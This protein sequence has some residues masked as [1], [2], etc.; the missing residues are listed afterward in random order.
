MT[1]IAHQVQ[2]KVLSCIKRKFPN[3]QQVEYFS[4]G[5]TGQYTNFKNV[6]KLCHH[7][8][9]FGLEATLPF[10]AASHGKSTCDDIGVTVKSANIKQ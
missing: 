7:K 8:C 2:K 1:C 4:D 3:L 10:F 5:C 6:L 9:D